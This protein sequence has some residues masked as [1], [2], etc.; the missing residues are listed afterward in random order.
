[1]ARGAGH[2]PGL[3]R[4]PVL[5]LLAFGEIALLA[6][7]HVE[8]L[9]P[10]ERRRLIALLREARGRPSSMSP[11]ERDELQRL[12]QKAAPREFAGLAVDRLSPVPLP[13]RLV[14]GRR[15]G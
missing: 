12:V 5:N 1:M 11:G 3:R 9:S 13:R 4:L 15:T 7:R 8:R 14:Y 2:V 6:K 10:A